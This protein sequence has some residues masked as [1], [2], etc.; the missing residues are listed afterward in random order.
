VP[1]PLAAPSGSGAAATTTTAP[2]G[3][4]SARRASLALMAGIVVLLLAVGGLTYALLNRDSGGGGNSAGGTSGGNGGSGSS[5]GGSSGGTSGGSSGGGSKGGS[6]GSSDSKGGNNGSGGGGSS[7]GGH[8]STPAQSVRVSVSAVRG[9]YSGT[10]PPPAAQAPAFAAT[11]T[12]GRTPAEVEYRWVTKSGEPSDPGW[13]TLSFGSGSARSRTVDT[14]QTAYEE[15][16]TLH[17]QIGVEV[18]APVAATSNYAA[19]SVTCKVVTPSSGA[20][21]GSPTYQG[22]AVRPR[23]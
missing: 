22:R 20:T 23:T 4:R 11:I 17:N 13:K 15:G 19:Y 8:T 5:G 6:T 16:G 3:E 14:A 7:G 10:C 1:V 9:S 12:V 21:T 18:R 2:A